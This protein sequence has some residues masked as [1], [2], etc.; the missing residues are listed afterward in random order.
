MKHQVVDLIPVA[1]WSV[2]LRGFRNCGSSVLLPLLAVNIQNYWV[3]WANAKTS[4]IIPNS[5]N[6]I[7]SKVKFPVL[8]TEII[9]LAETQFQP[10]STFWKTKPN[11]FGFMV[12]CIPC[13]TVYHNSWPGSIVSPEDGQGTPETCRDLLNKIIRSDKVG[14]TH[15]HTHTHTHIYIYIYI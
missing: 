12:P 14:H 11:L 13:I 3:Y 8:Y 5:H 15:T 2:H 6:F 7:T 1:Y 9:L 10:N 4:V